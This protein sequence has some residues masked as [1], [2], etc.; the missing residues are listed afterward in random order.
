MSVSDV[1]KAVEIARLLEKVAAVDAALTKAAANL[2]LFAAA[3]TLAALLKT[4]V[5]TAAPKNPPKIVVPPIAAPT[6][7]KRLP[8]A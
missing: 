1:D 6:E 5:S 8:A 2:V 7:A 4:L 3:A